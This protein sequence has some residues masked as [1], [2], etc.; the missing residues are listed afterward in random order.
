MKDQS[1]TESLITEPISKLASSASEV[2]TEVTSPATRKAVKRGVEKFK[3]RATELYDE[4]GD[5]TSLALRRANREVRRRPYQAI[6]L[7]AGVGFLLG[8]MLS[9]RFSKD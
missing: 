5:A 7:S 6:L 2:F 1:I 8:Y 9:R 3:K 4:A